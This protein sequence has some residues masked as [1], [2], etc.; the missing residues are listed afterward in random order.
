MDVPK[1]SPQKPA[2]F[3]LHFL[4]SVFLCKIA[5]LHIF[6]FFILLWEQTSRLSLTVFFTGF[7]VKLKR[8]IKWVENADFIYKRTY[9]WDVILCI[10]KKTAE[11]CCQGG[12]GT[13]SLVDQR[14]L[15][16]SIVF[17]SIQN[18]SKVRIWVANLTLR[19]FCRIFEITTVLCCVFG[20]R[21][22]GGQSLRYWLTVVK[23][24]I[25]IKYWNSL[26]KVGWL[27]AFI[28]GLLRKMLRNL[29]L[30]IL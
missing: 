18:F 10:K 17:L 28:V 5:S 14:I 22:G 7:F 27:S 2:N 16:E 23:Y 20:V 21:W 3:A 8:N 6:K 29:I 24:A 13:Y 25:L 11:P 19:Y 15:S 4:K 9:K 12:P 26:L 30:K 1:N